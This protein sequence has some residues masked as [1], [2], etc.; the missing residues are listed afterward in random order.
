[1]ASVRTKVLV[2]DDDADWRDFLLGCLWELGYDPFEAASGEEAL[3]WLAHE[4]PQIVLLDQKMPGLSGAQ[5][6]ERLPKNPPRIVF[7]T[8]S[9]AQ[10]LGPALASGP[11]YYLPKGA[12]REELSLILQSLAC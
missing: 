2:V 7:V 8:S 9:P 6:V 3:R 12:S 11:H 10:E 5:V 1:V 4:R